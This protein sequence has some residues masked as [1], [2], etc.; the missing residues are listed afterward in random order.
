VQALQKWLNAHG[1]QVAASGDG[2]PGHETSYFGNL[3]KAAVAK[4]QTANHIAPNAGYF[5]PKT[6]AVINNL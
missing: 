4:F 2:S 3:T 6:R 1:Y 5:G